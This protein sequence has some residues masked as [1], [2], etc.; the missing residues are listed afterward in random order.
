MQKTRP[1]RD[2]FIVSQRS[3]KIRRIAQDEGV[4]KCYSIRRVF[5]E[6]YSRSRA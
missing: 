4:V 6:K 1:N 2:D 5:N 3:A